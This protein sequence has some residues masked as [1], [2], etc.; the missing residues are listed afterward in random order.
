MIRVRGLFGE[1]YALC[2]TLEYDMAFLY[3]G[4]LICRNTVIYTVQ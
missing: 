4:R 2:E 1:A 3:L